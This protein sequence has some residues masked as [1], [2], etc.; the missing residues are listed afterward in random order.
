M[1]VMKFGGTS[2]A[3]AGRINNVYEIVKT[4]LHKKPIVVV[5]AG[6]G[7][8]DLLINTA[9][10]ATKGINPNEKTE[11]I[12]NIHKEIIKSLNLNE[13]FLMED[14]IRLYDTLNGV[15]L[16]KELS[17]RSI[18]LISSFGEIFSSKIV[19]EYFNSKDIQSKQY[20]G[21]DAGIVTNDDFTNSE[22]LEE[23]YE[24]IKSNLNHFNKLPIVTGFIAK[25][26]DGEIT[27]LGRGGSDYTAA[28]IGAALGADEIE[29]WTDVDGIKTADPRIVENAKQWNKVTFNEASEMAYFGAKVLH[30]KTIKPAVNKNI[31]VRVLN[32]YNINNPGTLI[33]KED[34]DECVFRTIS[35][36][37]NIIVIRLCSAEMLLAYGFLARVFEIFNKYKISI[38]LISTSEVTVSMT[39]DNLGNGQKELEQAIRELEKI[40]KVELLKDMSIICI[41]GKN[42]K[43]N[44][45]ILGR[46][47]NVCKTKDVNVEMISQGASPLSISF[48]VKQEDSDKIIKE[49][50]KELFEDE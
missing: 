7:V 27:T 49:L 40:G 14:F 30:P 9:K 21:W 32:T 6:S 34:N 12:I 11:E 36:K 4:R 37:N 10:E 42:I 5:S 35:V 3:N 25:N 16:L 22:I 39:L 23:T 29:I 8:T 46:I 50:H 17:P 33:I 2:L 44:S 38:D 28:I 47:F 26:K 48:V 43:E 15:Y 45:K 19:A 41:V 1:I 20:S 13:E 18:D 31:P 24:K